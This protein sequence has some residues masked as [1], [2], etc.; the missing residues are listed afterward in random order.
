MVDV[1]RFAKE[2]PDSINRL[3]L[4]DDD[5]SGLIA[6]SLA[7]TVDGDGATHMS[8]SV[9]VTRFGGTQ[10]IPITLSVEAGN[11]PAAH[12]H[13]NVSQAAAGSQL[14]VSTAPLVDQ[15]QPGASSEMSS[16]AEYYTPVGSPDESRQSSVAITIDEHAAASALTAAVVGKVGK[17]AVAAH[18]IFRDYFVNFAGSSV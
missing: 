8:V 16:D 6:S 9:D 5:D 2:N 14:S 18:F 17:F 4:T 15:R 1:I 13:D 7:D 12:H 11:N 10:P 3:G